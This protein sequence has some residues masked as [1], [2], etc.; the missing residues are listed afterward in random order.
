MAD[1]NLNAH[2]SKLQDILGKKITLDPTERSD[3][4]AIPSSRGNEKPSWEDE[5]VDL[6]MR[7]QG[8]ESNGLGAETAVNVVNPAKSPI[9]YKEVDSATLK[10]GQPVD[11]EIAFCPWH[12]VVH[13]PARFVGKRNKPR[14]QPFFDKILEGKTWDFFYLHD[15]TE[16]EQKPC[17]LIPTVQ[18]VGFLEGINQILASELVIPQGPNKRLFN[19]HF[20]VGGTPRPRYLLRSRDRKKLGIDEWPAA[21]EEDV[22]AYKDAADVHRD[23]WLSE[24]DKTKQHSFPENRGGTYRAEKSRAARLQM[25]SQ[26]QLHLGLQ[27][28]REPPARPVT[29]ICVDME[30]IEVAPNPV[31]EIGI[32]V[33]NSEHLKGVDAGPSGQNWW[34]FI[35]AHHI[36]VKEYAGLV[37]YRFIQGCPNNFDF[38]T[39]VFSLQAALIETLNATFA[40]YANGSHDVFLVGHDIKSDLGYLSNI[41]FPIS[42]LPGLVGNIDT[43]AIYRAW[44]DGTKSCSLG[45][46]LAD[47]DVRYKNL[48]NA[49]ND[50]V[51]TLR[52][53]VAIALAGLQPEQDTQ[54][55]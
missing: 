27:G 24:W 17:L 2:L 46:V 22:R 9:P 18:F 31:S 30:A 8:E 28:A 12:A 20:G 1:D 14:A 49:G 4:R 21:N 52:A 36:R 39:S 34:H 15:P 11:E 35:D 10:I 6:K 33:L 40:K 25:L 45:S 19:L 16:P 29:F 43:Q 13:Y 32:A 50:A 44:K 42:Q 41:G 53:M 48:H 7:H 38:G 47:L 54:V 51:Y 23:L 37:N 5:H 55:T 26:A 3:D